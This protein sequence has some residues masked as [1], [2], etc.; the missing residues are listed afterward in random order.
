MWQYTPYTIPFIGASLISAVLGFIIWRRNPNPEAKIGA[1]LM[2]AGTLWVMGYA[3]ELASADL[4]AKMVWFKV[5]N[6][7]TT[8]IPAGWFVF[9]LQYTGREKWVTRR[10][11]ILLSIMPAITVFVILTNETHHLFW[12]SFTLTPR[13]SYLIMHQT[14]GVWSWVYAAYSYILALLGIFYLAQVFIRTHHIYRLQT[15]A[16]LLVASVLL[17]GNTLD[18]AGW[19][20]LQTLGFA[21]L[22]FVVVDLAL[23]AALFFLGLRSIVPITRSVVVEGMTDIVIVL[24][25]KNLIMDANA[26]AARLIGSPV[27]ALLGKSIEE[28]LPGWSEH[29]DSAITGDAGSEVR[30]GAGEKRTY[31]V[32]VS[33]LRDWRDRIIS[34]AI[35]LRDITER[36]RTEEQVKTSLREKEVLL[37][38]IHH[39]VKNNLQIIS[40]LLSLQSSR[41]KDEKYVEMFKES[42]N[43]IKTMALIHEKL[44]QSQD[45]ADIDF[46]KY[47]RSLVNGLIYSYGVDT[48]VITVEMEVE[49]IPLGI[50][51][52]IPC[53][54]IIN[55]LVSNALK[56][57]FPPGR[58][59]TVKIVLHSLSDKIQLVVSDDGVGIPEEV[60]FRTT[61]SLGLRLVTILA[62][63]QLGGKIS[64]DRSNGTAFSIIFQRE[65]TG[66]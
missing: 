39:R 9:A 50:D 14:Y 21:P 53:G 33:H 19:N 30:L 36:K 54:L 10:H 63:D 62:E 16:V 2:V 61:E 25:A 46:E 1:L 42:Q 47:V 60:D 27:S 41:I 56:Y 13:G 23:I 5:R 32:K 22:A 4:S 29:F 57:A 38:E 34:R 7:G 6:V 35:V 18:I 65:I 12:T 17:V 44:Y 28:V 51:A 26:T 24:D 3:F 55:E 45:I 20:P 49:D 52:V 58:K 31:D 59:G 15:G 48:E 40:S 43:R 66:E 8:I 64:L 11:L 37:R